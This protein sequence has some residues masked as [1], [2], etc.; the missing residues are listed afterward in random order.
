MTRIVRMAARRPLAALALACIFPLALSIAVV[1][2]LAGRTE[3]NDALG[4]PRAVLGRVWFDAYP[5]KST[6]NVQ[7]WIWLGGGIGINETGSFWRTSFDIFEFER[8]GDKLSMVYLQ[9]KKTVDT[10][11]SI[12]ACDEKPPFDVCLDLTNALGG[13]SRYYGFGDEED[14]AARIPWAKTVLRS[15]E[16]RAQGP[17]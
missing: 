7:I 15:A 9:D 8:Q 11:F 12:K 10:R 5:K 3:K 6:D 13:H 2:L 1:A 4:N 14:M 17:R 16:A